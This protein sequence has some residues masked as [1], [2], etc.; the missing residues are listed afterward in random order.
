MEE[1]PVKAG[2][3]GPCWRSPMLQQLLYER[4]GGYYNV[5]YRAQLLKN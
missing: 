5:F 3:R 1:G 2:F 4:F